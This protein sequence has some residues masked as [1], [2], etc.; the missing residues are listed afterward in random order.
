MSKKRSK[1]EKKLKKKGKKKARG[2]MNLK[3]GE[4]Q[5][6]SENKRPFSPSTQ[7]AK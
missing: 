6:E 7:G 3:T 4:S 5:K 1:K 2:P